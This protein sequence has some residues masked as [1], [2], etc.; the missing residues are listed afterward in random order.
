M[1]VLCLMGTEDRLYLMRQALEELKNLT[2]HVFEGD[3]YS[4]WELRQS[5]LAD[6]MM[7]AL[8][9]YDFAIVYFHGGAHLMDR[10]STFWNG[11]KN[12]MPVFFLSSLAE[13]I[14]ELMPQSALNPEAYKRMISYFE[15]PTLKNYKSVLMLAGNEVNA[16]FDIP[17]LEVMPLQGYYMPEQLIEPHDEQTFVKEIMEKKLPIIGLIIHQNNI[18]TQNRAHINCAIETLQALGAAPLPVYTRIAEDENKKSGILHAINRYFIHDGKVVPEALIVMTGFSMTY[19][20]GYNN[21]PETMDKSIFE[22]LNIPVM[23]MMITHFSTQEYADK[24][25]G[26]DSMSLGTSVF[27]PE[28][29]GQIITVPSASME[30]RMIDSIE[31]KLASPMADRIRKTCLLAI[32]WAKL[33]KL[34]SSDKKLAIILHNLPGNDRIGCA[35]G[36]DTFESVYQLLALLKD[37]GIKTEYAFE[38]G[39]EILVKLTEALTNTNDYK[40][41][42]EIATQACDLILPE[43]YNQWWARFGDQISD[44]LKKRWGNPPGA[45]MMH[46]DQV[47]IPGLLN[48]NV[49][50]GLQPDRAYNNC[51]EALYHSTDFPPPYSYIAFYRWL[52]EVLKA[53]VVIHVGTHG[54]VEWL[55]GKEIGLSK[56][57]YPDICMGSLPHL[58]IYHMGITG[59]GIQ[60]KRRSH[61]VI[62]EHLIPS[63]Q[64]SGTYGELSALDDAIKAYNHANQF[65]KGQV[66]STLEQV[67][68]LAETLA[69]NSD[70]D[71]DE[72]DY[73][74]APDAYIRK[75]HHW[76]GQLKNSVTR[77]GLHIFG[78]APHGEPF[79]NLLRMLVRV[80]NHHIPSIYDAVLTAMGHDPE[81]VKDQLEATA[82]DSEAQY[83]YDEAVTIATE[84]THELHTH[85]YE[86]LFIQKII[87]K[88]AF[89]GHTQPLNEVLSYVCTTLKEKVLETCNEGHQFINGI[90][91]R[92][93]PPGKGG[94]PTRGNADILPTG[95]NFYAGDPAEIPSRAAYEVGV[96]LAQKTLDKYLSLS[97]A[98]PESVAMIVWAGNTLKT[99]GEDFAEGL[100]LMG[101]RPVYLGQ[102]ARV[103]DVEA[104]PM[105]E[106]KRPRID[107][108]LRVSGL[109][110]DM[111][112]NLI[113]LYDKA[114]NCVVALEE[115]HEENHVKRHFDED[116]KDLIQQGIDMDEASERSKIRVFSAAPGTYGAGVS[117]LIESKAWDSYEDIA[118]V[119]SNWSSHGYS[120]RQHGSRMQAMFEKR[121]S[122]VEV[123]IKN[124]SNIEV[125]MFSSD[126]F[127]AYHGGLVACVKKH[128]GKNPLAITGHTED[129]NRP[130]LRTL[131]AETA[132]IV[133]TK[134]FHPVWLE[135]LK[136]HGYKGAQEVVMAVN[137]LFGWDATSEVAED[138]M[139]Q[140]IAEQFLFDQE[141]RDWLESVNK[142]ST[143][144]I[145]ERLLESHQRGMWDADEEVVSQLRALYLNTE[146]LIEGD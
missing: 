82:T 26:L 92:F 74:S 102:T 50:I 104:I 91:A 45:F 25:Q 138:W 131:K 5:P 108:T 68:K 80:N 43:R 67:Y 27:Q 38:N 24:I 109:F 65:S 107:V 145:S 2:E 83:I 111:Y 84:L 146:G 124:E 134:I 116:I 64:E 13:E 6:Q 88:S 81:K 135:G 11:I 55:P 49:Y 95:R 4:V 69:L 101:V 113:E 140:K 120:S 112:P 66:Q 57:C 53:D 52:E 121:L 58:Y 54:T 63:M 90:N 33:G 77:D 16:H 123:T 141:N 76:M 127:Y 59:E 40:T 128:S 136:R 79:S 61:A 35:E 142:W 1:K 96:K 20:S 19:M 126:D 137:H 119:Y 118:D 125:D 3:I 62:L 56:A 110:R 46:D 41:E 144:S 30:M 48:G 129:A 99:Y 17:E 122:T 28:L 8:T 39:Q 72:N 18:M 7:S 106:L 42:D 21:I 85:K 78:Q 98:Y 89:R 86:V 132:R 15:V 87:Q 139:Y 34:K 100:S 143:H 115:N 114:V 32:N 93:V 117:H 44:H 9:T 51:A 103:V 22:R 31:R 94:N 37:E 70:I 10:F 36:L 60:A 105:I 47:I 73:K 71:L 23:Q 12:R 130:V 75:L 14:S 29:D 133:R 97:E